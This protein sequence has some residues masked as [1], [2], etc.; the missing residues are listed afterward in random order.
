MATFTLHKDLLTECPFDSNH[1]IATRNWIKHIIECEKKLGSKF[2]TCV[3]NASHRMPRHEFARHLNT[4]PDA[5]Q[6]ARETDTTATH[7]LA[8][9]TYTY[10]SQDSG[11]QQSTSSAIECTS[12]P[13]IATSAE[14]NEDNVDNWDD[15]NYPRYSIYDDFG[16][17]VAT[18]TQTDVANKTQKLTKNQKKNMRRKAAN[19][20]KPQTITTE[21]TSIWD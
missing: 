13:V 21:G 14:D 10:G 5:R 16:S 2:S 20:S 15:D 12:S 3:Y 8:Q 7:V 4:C 9:P 18:N 17:S 11:S 1:K 6:Y 19:A